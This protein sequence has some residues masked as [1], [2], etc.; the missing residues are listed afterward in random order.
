MHSTQSLELLVAGT[1]VVVVEVAAA[2]ETEVV[3]AVCPWE[4]RV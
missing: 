2:V 4:L 1:V 3:D